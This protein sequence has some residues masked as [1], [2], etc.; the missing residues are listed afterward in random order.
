M[1]RY[2]L[3][4]Y[5][6][7]ALKC[8]LIVFI[9]CSCESHASTPRFFTF[10]LVLV[11]MP[12][13]K[14]LKSQTKE[15]VLNVN[16]YFEELNR[17]KQTQRPLKQTADATGVSCTSIKRLQKEKVDTSG[18]AFSTPT[19]RCR[20]SRCLLVDDFDCEAIRRKIYH[21]YQAKEHVTLTQ[22]AS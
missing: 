10:S 5:I 4:Y 14:R 15:V 9:I 11:K 1:V 13:G 2:F 20:V 22:V 6:L 3:N 18:A 21:L 16:D 7:L 19:K 8:I 17:Y 12:T